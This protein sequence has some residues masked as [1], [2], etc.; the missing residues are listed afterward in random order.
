M[1]FEDILRQSTELL[2]EFKQSQPKKKRQ[3]IEQLGWKLRN[4][5]PLGRYEKEVLKEWQ[6][7]ILNRLTM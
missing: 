3:N 6:Q 4:N 1:D 7:F 5:K 2:I